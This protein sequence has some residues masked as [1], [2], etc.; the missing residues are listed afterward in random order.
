M[1]ITI[2]V[3]DRV[4]TPMGK[5]KVLEIEK[6]IDNK[7]TVRV[8]HNHVYASGV[9]REPRDYTETYPIDDVEKID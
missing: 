6:D 7:I 2:A 3:D 4:M 8:I 5:A 9:Q 1:D